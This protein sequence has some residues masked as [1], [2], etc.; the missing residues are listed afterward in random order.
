MVVVF[1]EADKIPFERDPDLLERALYLD[2]GRWVRV[3]AHLIIWLK[4][5][6]PISQHCFKGQIR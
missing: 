2:S 4:L 6:L 1:P 3:P 5:T